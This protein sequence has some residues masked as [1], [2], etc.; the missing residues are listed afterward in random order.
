[1]ARWRVFVGEVSKNDV[2]ESLNTYKNEASFQI[3]GIDFLSKL[4]P[5]G[6]GPSRKVLEEKFQTSKNSNLCGRGPHPFIARI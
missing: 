3:L 4:G 6:S 2:L 1:M 5:F